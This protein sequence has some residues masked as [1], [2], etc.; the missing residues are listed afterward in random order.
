ML[1]HRMYIL[2][3]SHDTHVIF[4]NTFQNNFMGRFVLQT[5]PARLVLIWGERKLKQTSST[6][7]KMVSYPD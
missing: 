6:L 2:S 1:D 7:Y 4:R 5:I 3:C